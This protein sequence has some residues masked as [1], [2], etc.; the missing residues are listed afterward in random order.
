MEFQTPKIER[1]DLNEPGTLSEN[2]ILPWQHAPSEE[3][4]QAI[5]QQIQSAEGMAGEGQKSAADA[6]SAIWSRGRSGMS[7]ALSSRANKL[8]SLGQKSN[9]LNLGNKNVNR[10]RREI[11]RIGS[12]L[13]DIERLKK[14]NTEGQL[15]YAD[16]IAD[17]NNNLEI[18]KFQVLGNIIGGM[19]AFYG[20]AAGNMSKG[21]LG[22]E[23]SKKH[24]FSPGVAE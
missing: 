2:R 21:G 10:Q 17:Y 5:G 11:G 4:H 3:T 20:S 15:R 7:Q 12:E 18:A 22:Q 9:E 24:P 6:A 23:M 1:V 13:N 8:F 19:G 16:Q 14:L